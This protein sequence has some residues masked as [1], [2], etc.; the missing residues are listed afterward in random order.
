[1][2]TK[3]KR[4]TNFKKDKINLDIKNNIVEF[5][6]DKYKMES[7][8]GE[9]S[10]NALIF[11]IRNTDNNRV[12]ILKIT[13]NSI[14]PDNLK[15]FIESYDSGI[16]EYKI[17]DTLSNIEQFE[18]ISPKVY[19]YSYIINN[20]NVKGFFKKNLDLKIKELTKSYNKIFNEKYLELVIMEFIKGKTY[21]KKCSKKKLNKEESK[22]CNEYTDN[23]CSI[24]DLLHN[25]GIN[26]N[27][28]HLNNIMI[29][30]DR[31]Y[32]IDWARAK[33]SNNKVNWEDEIA[34]HQGKPKWNKEP[35]K[36]Y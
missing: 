18:N 9:Y 34:E 33:V 24:M 31:P 26:H 23:I 21:Y 35:R 4:K 14:K 28:L 12:Y 1:M 22:K 5:G 32:I 11:K 15:T 10:T 20:D 6:N 19:H 2:V 29:S 16:H 17:L 13:H 27:D 3:T 7:R 8:I 30:K 25:D 36:C